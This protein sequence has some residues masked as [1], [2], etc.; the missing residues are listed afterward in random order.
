MTQA[1]AQD[2]AIGDPVDGKVVWSDESEVVARINQEIRK[3]Q[4]DMMGQL[5]Q[6]AD[7]DNEIIIDGNKWS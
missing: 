2:I 4:S 3:E 6:G 7:I 5:P 1:S